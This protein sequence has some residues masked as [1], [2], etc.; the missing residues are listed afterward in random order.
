MK[1]HRI[2]ISDVSDYFPSILSLD[3]NKSSRLNIVN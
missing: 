3:I 2:I 1:C